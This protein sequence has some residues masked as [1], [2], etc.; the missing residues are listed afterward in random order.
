MLPY[1]GRSATIQ[2][3]V[4]R[5]IDERSGEMVELSTDCYILEGVV[6]KGYIS[7]GRWFCCRGIYPWWRE[8]WLDPEP[9]SS[10]SARG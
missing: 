9:G 1:C 8:A 3:K 10:S 5:F 6:C 7:D 4:D 2:T